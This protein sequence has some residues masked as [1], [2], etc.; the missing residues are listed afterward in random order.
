MGEGSQAEGIRPSVLHRLFGAYL[1]D[2]DGTVWL[3]E[4]L[5]PG[6]QR[7]HAQRH[8]LLP[9]ARTVI[10]ALR[11]RGC[12]VAFM[13]NNA[14]GTRESFAQELCDLGVPCT[15]DDVVCT[16]FVMAR[17]LSSQQPGARCYV[18]GPDPLREELY[19][20]GLT[21]RDRPGDIDFVVVGI[22]R[23]FT[24]HKLQTAFEAIRAGAR[25]VATNPDPW[26]PAAHG[27]LADIGALIAAI[28]VASERRLDKL[29]GKPD[30][31]I[32]QI[33]LESLTVESADCL[34]VGDQLETDVL[35][36]WR[37]GVP[38]AL[39]LRDPRV[40]AQLQ[41]WQ[42]QPDIL[43]ESLRDLIV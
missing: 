21:L 30:P 42:H 31:F 41:D 35:A 34:I 19:R 36:G 4:E 38:V 22:D 17:Y 2:L 13:T 39:L 37:A 14:D 12:R 18:I 6:A 32:V 11:S 40:V 26:V 27:D 15:P 29:V 43:L 23:D 16:A 8:V 9:D 1:F 10:G 7:E 24:Y 3:T 25:L 20:A 5:V 33:A 28:E